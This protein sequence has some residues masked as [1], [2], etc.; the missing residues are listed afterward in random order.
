V[1]DLAAERA[2]R[3]GRGS[4]S[5][6]GLTWAHWGGMAASLAL[7]VLLGHQWA[8]PG[9]DALV[10]EAGGRLVAGGRL[11]QALEARLAADASGQGVAV[12]LSFVDRDGQYCRTFSTDRIAGLACRE[13]SR[14]TVQSTTPAEPAASGALRQAASPLPRALLEAVDERIAGTA[15]TAAQERQARDRGWVR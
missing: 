10:S 15:L 11:A 5:G 12:Q 13:A 14:W 2:R 3:Q 8:A 4:G 6:S 9:A 7:G 1:A